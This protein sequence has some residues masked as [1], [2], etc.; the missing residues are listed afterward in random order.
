MKKVFID[1]GHGGTDPGAI[2]N[3]LLE[4]VLTRKIGEYAKVYLETVYEG[5]LVQLSRNGDETKSLKQRTDEA[6]AWGADVLS[7]IHIN[8]SAIKTS[9]GFESHIYP[10]SDTP[11]VAL[12]NLIHAE[13]IQVMKAF[14]I[15]NDRGKKQSD[16]HML[17]ESDMPAVLTENLFIV[18]IFDANRLKQEAFLKAVGDAHARGIAKFIGLK[19]KPSIS[20]EA[21]VES[22]GWMGEKKDGETA[23]TTGQAK[24]LE[25][26]RINSNARL[27]M[28]G[29][30]QNKGWT[31]IKTNGEIVGTVGE[32]LRLEAIK[33]RCEGHAVSYRVHVQDIGWSEWK[34]NGEVAG[35]TGQSKRIEAI[36]IKIV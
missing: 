15:T 8:S 20:Y 30:I 16:F 32:S 33:I 2:G 27:E 6:N 12:Q 28:E 29:H 23:G 4:K 1:L 19:E 9:N 14:G 10:N 13:I 17:R 26:F 21:H 35:T 25:A 36:E 24:R 7:S 18:N 5:A 11:T 3:D 22:Y 31:P 34:H